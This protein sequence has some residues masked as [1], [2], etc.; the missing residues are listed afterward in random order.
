MDPTYDHLHLPPGS[1][2][3]I[4]Y[5]ECPGRRDAESHSCQRRVMGQR[6]LSLLR[7][8]RSRSGSWGLYP[9][10]PDPP[11]CSWWCRRY[12]GRSN[13]L[14][15]PSDECC[16]SRRSPGHHRLLRRPRSL[17]S[18]LPVTLVY[19]EGACYPQRCLLFRL[20]FG[21][22]VQRPDSLRHCY[23]LLTQAAIRTVAVALP[24][25]GHSFYRLRPPCLGFPSPHPGKTQVGIHA[26]RKKTGCHSNATGT[27]YS[28]LQNPM[29][30]GSAGFQVSHALRIHHASY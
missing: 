7:R 19:T 29:E 30:G 1:H 25:R 4:R 12:L 16:S 17:C 28:W 27:Q 14:H 15:D 10:K 24:H 2:G 20:K 13:Y 26:R 6:R 9:Q 8:I 11:D 3:P 22:C 21:W 5:W 23:Q 18:A